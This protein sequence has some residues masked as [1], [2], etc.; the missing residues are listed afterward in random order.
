MGTKQPA[1]RNQYGDGTIFQRTR[2]LSHAHLCW[3]G[4][5]ERKR[6]SFTL[7]REPEETDRQFHK[8]VEAEPDN[9]IIQRRE[10][11]DLAPKRLTVAAFLER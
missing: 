6:K 7:K 11:V 10:G 9:L 3:H 8:R 2:H 5:G 4:K 1:K